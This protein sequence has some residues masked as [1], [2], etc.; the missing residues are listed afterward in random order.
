MKFVILFLFIFSV[1][2]F[3]C[4]Q[5]ADNQKLQTRIDSL[6]HQLANAYKPGLGEFM[7]GIQVHHIKLWFAGQNKN[8]GLADFEINEIKEA[9]TGIQKYCKDRPEISNIEMINPAIDAVSDAIHKKDPDQFKNS[10]G[11]LTTTCNT[12]HQATQHQFNIIKIPDNPPFSDQDFQV[13]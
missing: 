6:E 13:R 4:N 11:L 9:L 8:W 7:S 2:L 10:Y 1:A 12:C 5:S 3:A